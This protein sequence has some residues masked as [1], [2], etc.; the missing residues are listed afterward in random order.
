MPGRAE[1]LY[2]R[3]LKKALKG[4][5]GDPVGTVAFYGPDD[6]HAS[7]LV[8]GISPDRNIGITETRRWFTEGPAN[9]VRRDVK[10]L[11][12]VLAFMSEQGVK[13]VVM[14]DG[15]YGCPHEAGVDYP[16]D[17]ACGECSFWQNRSREV[18]VISGPSSKRRVS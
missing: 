17:E 9:D 12:E 1:N 16:E 4:H 18:G 13:S 10:T 15:V 11:E 8:V 5:R 2:Q 14:T 3:I 7:K 6:Q